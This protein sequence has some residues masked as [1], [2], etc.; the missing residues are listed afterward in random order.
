MWPV[1][2]EMGL[3]SRSPDIS[4][5]SCLNYIIQINEPNKSQASRLGFVCLC[6]MGVFSMVSSLPRLILQLAPGTL[7]NE[8]KSFLSGERIHFI[9]SECGVIVLNFWVQV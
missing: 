7:A 8:R 9:Y 2:A 3:N 6:C 1:T 4:V 5:Q